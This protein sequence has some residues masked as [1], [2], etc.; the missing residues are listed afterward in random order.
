MNHEIVV[1]KYFTFLYFY[2]YFAAIIWQCRLDFTIRDPRKGN[3]Q[4]KSAAL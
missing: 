1:I 2:L 4:N 3:W